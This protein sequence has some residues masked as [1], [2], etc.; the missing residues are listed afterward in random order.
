MEMGDAILV[1]KREEMGVDYVVE[2]SG[3]EDIQSRNW[4]RRRRRFLRVSDDSPAVFR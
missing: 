1:G 2:R 3:F 4:G